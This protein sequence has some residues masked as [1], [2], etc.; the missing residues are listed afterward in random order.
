[1]YEGVEEIPKGW[2]IAGAVVALMLI[3]GLVF[4]LIE[5]GSL[6]HLHLPKLSPHAQSKTTQGKLTVVQD[7]SKAKFN[8]M[9]PADNPQWQFDAKGVVFDATKGV[10]NYRLTM[11]DDTKVTI[12]QQPMP[13]Q[14]KP[15]DSSAKFNQFIAASNVTM[16]EPVGQ[17]KVYFEAALSNGAPANGA[18]T[19]IYATDKILMFGQAQGVLPFSKWAQLFGVMNF[20]NAAQ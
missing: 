7:A 19:A 9:V 2:R 20:E 18:T 1:M 13:D 5:M 15:W 16:S 8:F 6:L 3:V 17:G 14:L 4:M 12:S 10:V 11:S